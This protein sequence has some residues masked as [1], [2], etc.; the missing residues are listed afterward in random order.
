M[1][2]SE[3]PSERP[4]G[5]RLRFTAVSAILV[6]TTIGAAG[7]SALSFAR[8]SSV[9]GTTVS[10]AEIT[11]SATSG[12]TSALERE[13]DALLLALSDPAGG[14][15][16]IDA[17]RATTDAALAHLDALLSTP[18]ERAA[19]GA[20]SRDTHAYRSAVDTLVVATGAADGVARYHRDV[21]PLLRSVVGRAGDIR[22]R[23]FQATQEVAVRARDDARHATLIVSFIALTA[24]LLSVAGVLY[25]GRVVI[26]PL[27]ELGRSVT[28]IR[29]GDFDQRAPV[30]AEGELGTLADDINRMAEDLAAFKRTNVREVMRAKRT[31][32]ATLEALPDAVL[33]VQGDRT[34]SM[35]N[36]AATALLGPPPDESKLRGLTLKRRKLGALP[37]PAHTLAMVEAALSGQ[38]PE[39]GA[40]DL[41]ETVKLQTR[42]LLP[43]VLSVRAGSGGE[44]AAVMVLYDV[45][46]FVRLDERRVELVAVASHE[47]R[48]PLTTIHMALSLLAEAS[49]QREPRDQALLTT[50]FAGV[51]QLAR[52]VDEFLDLTRIEAGQLR[53][54]WDR[55]DVPMLVRDAAALVEPRC[56]ELGTRLQIDV[57]ETTVQGDKARLSAVLQN[58]LANAVRYTAEGVITVRAQ[59]AGKSLELDVSDTGAGVPEDFRERIFEKFFRVEHE[60]PPSEEHGDRGSGIGLYLVRQITEAH[61][62]T[63][64]CFAGDGG[65]GT[66]MHVVLPLVRA[67]DT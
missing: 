16:E 44:P 43:R 58:L 25:L 6:A 22:D 62:G 50:A 8:F 63:V 34:I 56:E 31:L 15:R 20:L 27:R 41:R 55:V 29:Q 9:I 18:E 49:E 1:A 36:A 13:D 61:G 40:L 4:L 10:D 46:D 3:I 21:N 65:V 45:T 17:S 33:V 42:E 48:T 23:H 7:W 66:R 26:W 38:A 51:E 35:Q 53:L 67:Q 59:V 47:L 30:H 2:S 14:K 57:P 32:E 52:T 39:R 60:R 19:A 54:N 37:L 24:L 64:R 11:T 5:L 12:L 28:A